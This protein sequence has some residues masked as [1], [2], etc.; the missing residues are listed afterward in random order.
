MGESGLPQS[1]CC[2]VGAGS[3]DG[4]RSFHLCSLLC[5]AAVAA[6][7]AVAVASFGD[8][9]EP[10]LLALPQRTAWQGVSECV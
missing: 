6:A 5:P 3:W 10:R 2:G 7:V 1:W 8:A 4:D 9:R